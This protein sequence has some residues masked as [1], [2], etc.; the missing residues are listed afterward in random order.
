MECIIIAETPQQAADFAANLRLSDWVMW[1]Y[2][3]LQNNVEQRELLYPIT[4]AIIF[5]LWTEYPYPEVR[6]CFRWRE[7]TVYHIRQVTH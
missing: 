2:D 7:N 4:G 6:N 1:S 3:S 5:L